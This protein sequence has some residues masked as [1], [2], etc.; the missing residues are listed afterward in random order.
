M[1]VKIGAQ[2]YTIRNFC[3]TLDE[4]EK[5]CKKISEIGYKY[6]QLSGIGNFSA[7]S[8]KAVLDKYGLQV[9]FT[10]R[11]QKNFLASLEKE[12]EF[13]KALGCKVSGIS[14]IPGSNVR[15]E[16]I[17]SFIDNFLP[18]AKRLKEAGMDFSYHNNALDF[19]KIG[20]KYVLD[21]ILEKMGRENIKLILDIYWIAFAGLSPAK[22]I[23]KY[24]GNI[25]CVHFKDLKVS[26]NEIR[27]VEVGKGN[28]DW[29]E[30]ISA[31]EEAGVE[32]AMVEQD[33]CDKNPFDS[34]KI[35]YEFLK[36][37]GLE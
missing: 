12:I 18:V 7:Q 28:I 24:S 5:S 19:E 22:L 10:H 6:V 32:Y 35:S 13:H 37:K 14:A 20:D 33:V 11:E 36:E 21:I 34:L 17:T 31:C 25:A 23:R 1:S 15:E 26:N 3:K 9:V 2:F 27:F 29:A 30:V 4:F 16:T 8:I